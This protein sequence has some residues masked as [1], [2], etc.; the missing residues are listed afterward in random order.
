MAKEFDFKSIEFPL[1]GLNRRWSLQRQPDYTTPDALNVW[2]FTR[3]DMRLRGGSRPGTSA[4][5]SN[6]TGG[7]VNMLT[8]L[9]GSRYR[10]VPGEEPGVDGADGM[11]DKWVLASFF[12][13]FA[14]DEIKPWWESA[15]GNPLPD[16][17]STPP[18]GMYHAPVS[19]VRTRLSYSQ[20]DPIT[21]SMSVAST[22]GHSDNGRYSV[23]CGLRDTN[24]TEAGGIMATLIKFDGGMSVEVRVNGSV[25]H[26]GDVE[27][28]RGGSLSITMNADGSSIIGYGGARV[29]ETAAAVMPGTRIGFTLEATEEGAVACID[30]I[31]MT[32]YESIESWPPEDYDGQTGKYVLDKYA[33]ILV[34][35]CRGDIWYSEEGDRVN[36]MRKVETAVKT[37]QTGYVMAQ[38]R[39]RE[40]FVAD[41]GDY[42]GIGTDGSVASG[43][44]TAAS[45]TDWGTLGIVPGSDVAVISNASTGVSQGAFVVES[46]EA[47]GITL[48]NYSGEDGTC[49]WSVCVSPKVYDHG[50]KSYVPMVATQGMVPVNCPIVCLYRDRLVLA[51]AASEPHLWYMSRAGDP[52][53]WSYAIDTSVE[54]NDV[55]IAVAGQSS[56]AGTIG[57]PIRAVCPHSDDY[58]VFGYDRELWVLRGDPA[59]GGQLDNLSRTVGIVGRRAWCYGDS[60]EI[61]FMAKDGVYSLTGANG[62]PQVV[63]RAKLP[64]ELMGMTEADNVQMVYD[65]EFHGVHIYSGLATHWFVSLDTGGMFPMA[66]SSQARPMA[67]TSYGGKVLLGCEDGFIRSFFRELGDDDGVAMESYVIFGPFRVFAGDYSNGVVQRICVSMSLGDE[68]MELQVATADE[69]FELESRMLNGRYDRITFRRD[70]DTLLMRERGGAMCVRAMRTGHEGWGVERIGLYV[71]RAGRMR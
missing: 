54:G 23:M 10:F 61:V 6:G 57:E 19:A 2:P 67:V 50:Q 60:G 68:P 62:V 9:N 5:A 32:Y 28:Q 18:N 12:D 64:D 21:V 58:L 36:R 39:L 20:S 59:D 15:F 48:R 70:V 11:V 49:A 47:N 26:S 17:S 45:V 52:Y 63:S 55:G 34:A 24:P 8:S 44:L 13:D 7:K 65:V 25:V 14:G 30:S 38:K 1:G 56:L 4:W 31:S 51:G 22:S 66:F 27:G 35:G 33:D 29:C 40:L 42:I 37:R 46:V 3:R 71:R 69:A 43:K 16:V 41:Y 53:D